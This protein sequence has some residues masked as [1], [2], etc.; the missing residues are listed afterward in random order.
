[1]TQDWT[2]ES[3]AQAMLEVFPGLGRVVAVR[4]R[5]TGEEEATFMQMGVLMRIQERPIRTSDLAKMRKVSMQS[6]SVLVQALV[7]RGWLTRTPD[8]N[9]RR[10]S[11]LEVTPEGA[12]R[13][14]TVQQQMIQ[15]IASILNDLTPEE[16]H[17][18]GVF[19]PALRRV[20]ATQL[21]PEDV[22]DPLP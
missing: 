22:M 2:P 18:G 14:K 7:D 12:A 16:L 9:D 10:Q 1:M 19:L 20:I 15:L 6:A 4:M 21:H 3:T 11:L 8:P 5:D 17:A 13:A